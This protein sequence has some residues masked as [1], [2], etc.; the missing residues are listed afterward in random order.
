MIPGLLMNYLASNPAL[1][2]PHSGQLSYIELYNWVWGLS[3]SYRQ[4]LELLK[5]RIIFTSGSKNV[6][7]RETVLPR[8][9]IMDSSTTV[10]HDHL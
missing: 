2:V 9:N 1:M 3:G 5:Y 10:N 6:E 4:N 8:I 7:I